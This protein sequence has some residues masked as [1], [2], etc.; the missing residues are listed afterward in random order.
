M[1][2]YTCS[3]CSFLYDED[4]A[5][6]DKEGYII[7]FKDVDPEWTCPNCGAAQDL[8]YQAGEEEYYR[9]EERK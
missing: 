7:D 5:E 8:F 9:D 2:I 3:V 1:Q 4:A 6:R